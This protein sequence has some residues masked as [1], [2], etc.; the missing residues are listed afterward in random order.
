MNLRKHTAILLNGFVIVAPVLVTIY[1]VVWVVGK[2]D[3]LVLEKL[4]G[5]PAWAF[6]G[7]GV[8][9]A[10]V[11]IYMVGL[12]AKVWLFDKAIRMGESVVARIP[13]VKSIYG[14]I[15]DML[16][17]FGGEDRAAGRPVTVTLDNGQMKLLGMV[18][19][20]STGHILHDDEDRV[21]VYLPMSYQLGGYTAFVPREA[22][23][24]LE[25]MTVED[26]LKLALTGGAGDATTPAQGEPEQP[27]D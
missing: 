20:D 5:A 2:L 13:L 16:Q 11:A 18:T 17:L 21:A 3:T 23:T 25:H 26:L 19:Q 14:A 7:L 1:V 4:L 15:R 9:L 10:I 12:G 8:L 22:V 24:P 6:H 27:Q